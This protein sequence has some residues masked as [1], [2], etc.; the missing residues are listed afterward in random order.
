MEYMVLVL[1]LLALLLAPGGFRWLLAPQWSAAALLAHV[2][3]NDRRATTNYL[4]YFIAGSALLV[5]AFRLVGV[6]AAGTPEPAGTTLYGISL[7]LLGLSGLVAIGHYAY[8]LRF[9]FWD[10][11]TPLFGGRMEV[12]DVI[13]RIQR[14]R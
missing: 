6:L 11:T 8:V 9:L 1:H 2:K 10:R 4:L 12:E 7:W 13:G 5:F 14:Q 3:P